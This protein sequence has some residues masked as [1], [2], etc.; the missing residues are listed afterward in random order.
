MSVPAGFRDEAEWEQWKAELHTAQD[1]LRAVGDQ[2]ERLRASA[3][4]D[5]ARQSGILSSIPVPAEVRDALATAKRIESLLPYLPDVEVP[6]WAA[7]LASILALVARALG[8]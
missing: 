2:A 7:K 6:A 1:R 4:A 8:V 3:L 5:M